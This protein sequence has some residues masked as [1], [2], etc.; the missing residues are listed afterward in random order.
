MTLHLAAA[1]MPEG[2]RE[3]VSLT[4]D[5][6]GRILEVGQ[7]DAALALPGLA[8]PGLVNAHTHLDLD[9]PLVPSEGLPAWVRGLPGPSDA[10]GRVDDLLRFGTAGVVEVSNTLQALPALYGSPLAW[11]AHREILGIDVQALAQ[12]N[13]RRRDARVRLS[14]HAPYSTS[15]A[16]IRATVASSQALMAIIHCDED[17][18]EREFLERG[19]GAWRAFIQDL[20]RDLSAFEAP[21]C[22]PVPYLD[23][24]GVLNER[25][26]LVHCTLTRDVDLDLIAARGATVVLCPR[27]NLH[28]TGA[29]PDVPGMVARGIPL[30]LGTDSLA[31]CP[32]LDLMKE[33]AVLR[34]AFPELPEVTWLHAATSGG[35]RVMGRQDLGRLAVG[36]RP[37]IWLEGRWLVPPGGSPTC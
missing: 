29:L 9:G 19:E 3:S 6:E 24:L 10:R 34:E 26:A 32:D 28:I 8:T 12:D 20:G 30:A 15:A 31:S 14:P 1:L 27:S 35:A 21:G 23:R 16:L 7:A 17:L 5:E 22:T 25:I 36:C 37:G 2:V 33:V 13:R 4:V 18:A 11:V